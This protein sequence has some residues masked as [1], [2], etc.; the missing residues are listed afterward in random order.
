MADVQI[1]MTQCEALVLFEV[2]SRFAD[3]GILG[4]QDQSEQRAL[5]NLQCLLETV[6]PE[7]LHRNYGQLLADA[8]DELRDGDGTNSQFEAE[9]G[10]IAFWIDPTDV[11][12]LVDEWRKMPQSDPDPERERWANIAFRGMAALHKAGIK[13]QAKPPTTVYDSVRRKPDSDDDTRIELP[14]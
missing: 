9:K 13:Y 4:T 14:S 2:L 5:W 12:F 6:L 3:K 1:T 8:Q 10:R 11:A 7:A